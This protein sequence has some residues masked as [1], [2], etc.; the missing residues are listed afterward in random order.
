MKARVQIMPRVGVL[1]LQV[2]SFLD[3][4]QGTSG[5][6]LQPLPKPDAAMFM[7]APDSDAAPDRTNV[8]TRTRG[9]GALV[10]GPRPE[11]APRPVEPAAP[12]APQPVH[13]NHLASDLPITRH[14]DT[15]V[16][17]IA[18]NQIVIISGSTGSGK[19]TQVPQY[20]LDEHLRANRNVNIICTQPRRIAAISI[21]R[22][23]SEE[24]GL[25]LGS[26]IGY[27][28]SLDKQAQDD[29]RLLYVT[30]G[31][32]LQRLINNK[33]LKPFTHVIIDEGPWPA[34]IPP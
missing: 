14:R 21:A 29:T 32:L 7:A 8:P 3:R 1:A 2:N 30:T 26:M 25:Q 16:R 17:L 6:G 5:T 23:V 15:I 11:R 27:Q 22:R 18:S 24:R 34:A 19:T 31:I 12:D 20:I 10:F 28:V 4:Y 13:L 9:V 33:S